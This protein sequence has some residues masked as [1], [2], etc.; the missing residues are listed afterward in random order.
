MSNTFITKDAK[1][2]NTNITTIYND[3]R[4]GKYMQK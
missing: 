1:V 3:N 4:N 2:K